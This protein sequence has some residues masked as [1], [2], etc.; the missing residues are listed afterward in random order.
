MKYAAIAVLC[1]LAALASRAEVIDR[2][3]ATVNGRPILESDV[4]EAARYEAF[5]E[6]KPLDK[7]TS[8]DLHHT[9]DRL[10][11]HE[12][13]RQQAGDIPFDV[14]N[15]AVQQKIAE[16]QKQR[17]TTAAQWRDAL[18]A[19]GLSEAEFT[20]RLTDQ[21]RTLALV[22]RRLRPSIVIERSAVEAY[23][24]NVLLPKLHQ[25]GVTKDPPFNEVQHSIREILT[26]QQIDETLVNTLRVLRQQA[27]IHILVDN[28]EATD[29]VP[30]PAAK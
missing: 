4:D 13:L 22:D 18:A 15:D 24:R 17:G 30:S 10:I 27:T 6:E 28:G 25:E 21:L 26:Q 19:Y 11:D 14:S 23:Y 3:V 20:A 1:C 9:L 8:A 16:L 12:L 2:V 7:V 5:V 29:S